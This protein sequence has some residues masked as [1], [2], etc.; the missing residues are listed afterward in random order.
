MVNFVSP[1]VYVIE[2]DLSDYT[3]AVNPTVVG[4]VGFASKGKPNKAT[5]I[6]S[7]ESLIQTFGEPSEAIP[8]QAI[9]GALE[10][11]ETCN[12]LYFVRALDSDTASDASALVPMGSCPALAVSAN[13]YGVNNPLYLKVQ[14]TNNAG[15]NQFVTTKS[16]AIPAGTSVGGA[17]ATTQAQAMA[18]VLGGSMD[19][20]KVGS[21]YESSAVDSTIF[22]GIGNYIV[23]NF[24][25]SGATLTVSAYSDSAYTVPTYPLMPLTQH[26]MASGVSGINPA[27][28]NANGGASGFNS[29]SI[30]GWSFLDGSATSGLG[31]LTESLYEGAAYNLSTTTAGDTIG[32]SITV[33]ALGDRNNTLNVNDQGATAE[34]FKVSLVASGAFVEDVINTNETDSVVSNF[35]KGNIYHNNTNAT[36]T[37]LT[38]YANRVTG[39]AGGVL[40]SGGAITVAG[41]WNG[42]GATVAP[43]TLSTSVAAVTAAQLDT[44]FAKFRSGTTGLVGGTNGVGTG[45]TDET[46]ALIGE[47][48]PTR[49]GMQ[50][51]NDDLVPITLGA[52]PGITTENVQNNLVTLAATTGDFLAV[53]GT[54]YGLGGVQDAI[55]YSNGLTS[56]RSSPLNS[57]YAA[58]YYPQVKVFQSYLAKDIWLDPSIFAIRQM[59]FT[60]S[61]SELWFAPAGFQRGKLTKPTE[62]EVSIN[63]GDRDSMYSGGNIVNPIV[64]FAQQG[65]TIFGQRTTQREP[66]AL[67]RINV[68]RLMIFIKRTIEVSTQR[69]I[70]EPN[71]KITQEAISNLITPFFEDIQ[72]RRGIQEF[73]VICDETVNTPVRVD[74]NEL[75]CKIM[76][77]PTKTAEILI[78]ELNITNQGAQF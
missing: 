75:W 69:F 53:L 2:K 58:L 77:K 49:T 40:G 38:N 16:F 59:G 8:G 48:A 7:Q 39:L 37:K 60:D 24:A 46:A 72:N 29:V 31:Y 28:H 22:S 1:G 14:I 6:T 50:A 44:R 34:S 57:S 41:I 17:A 67:D 52:V 73:R 54:P 11:L 35:I 5:L 21:Y 26:G 33:N 74:R 15:A 55:D 43:E 61:V 13:S 78:F 18:S 47:T 42:D 9:E 56:Y 70:F 23:G 20:S 25:G 68:R 19:D 10:I 4:L 45:G 30:T 66:T 63:R 51:L 3:P 32:N 36:F 65:I 12:Q 64:N 71:D 27:D 76:I 62:L